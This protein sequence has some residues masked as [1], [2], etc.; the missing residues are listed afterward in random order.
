MHDFDGSL[1]FPVH[2][3]A[4]DLTWDELPAYFYD[5]PFTGNGL[6]GAV[7]HRMDRNRFDGDTD[8][9]LWEINRTDLT[10]PDPGQAEGHQWSRMAVG[11][12]ELKPVGRF[13]SSS[14][15]LDLWNAEVRG[16]VVTESGRI[17]VRHYAHATRQ[18]LITEVACAGD[19]SVTELR[20]APDVAGRI[21][22]FGSVDFQESATYEAYAP[23]VVSVRD[24]ITTRRQPLGEQ[25]RSFTVGWSNAVAGRTLTHIA[26]ITVSHPVVVAACDAHDLLSV[27]IGLDSAALA[28]EHRAWWHAFHLRRFVS[29]PDKEVESL[30]WR[31]TY[32]I[33]SCMRAGMQMMDLMGPWYCHTPWRAIW[34]NW[35]TQG[36]YLPLASMNYAEAMMPLIDMLWNQRD[37][38]HTNVPSQYRGAAA[39]IGRAS[40]FDC[41]SRVDFDCGE[42]YGGREA[43][44]LV[45]ALHPAVLYCRVTGDEKTLRERV[46]PLLVSAV[47]FYLNLVHEGDD[48]RLHLPVT[49]SPEYHAA[50]DCSYDLSLLRW[51]C[52]TLLDVSGRLGIS[53]EHAGRWRDVLERLAEPHVDGTGIMIGK[54]VALTSSHRHFSHLLALFPL[55]I[56]DL[57]ASASRAL[58]RRSVEHWLSMKEGLAAWSHAVASCMYAMLGDGDRAH[59]H[60]QVYRRGLTRSTQYREAGMCSE[61]AH[62]AVETVNRM[63]LQCVQGVIRVFPA[64]PSSWPDAS[65]ASLAVEGGFLVSAVRRAGTTVWVRVESVSGEPCTVACGI[66]ADSLHVFGVDE[67]AWSVVD[68]HVSLVLARGAAA[69]LCRAGSEH[70]TPAAVGALRG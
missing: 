2:L 47:G 63:I 64:V 42:P 17:T 56:V 57:S 39:A 50:A 10:V 13:L 62:M 7:I 70:E 52:G 67:S 28:G 69:I 21:A 8:K 54:D 55:G 15:R 36:M 60:L 59:E 22:T 19:E 58:M 53:H 24:G 48:G 14:W 3:A 37:N 32:A 29:L 23:A 27:S 35:N 26:T 11:R 44:N 68:D 66:D 61:T 20:F 6:L 40:G 4:Q 41:V 25:D 45:W 5:G 30:W 12:F 18:L 16:E 49:Y 46:F 51:G 9:I 38:L 65:F 34:W 43:G 33:G 31:R 1:E